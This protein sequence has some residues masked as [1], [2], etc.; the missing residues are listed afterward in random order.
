MGHTL[1]PCPM[2]HAAVAT[3]HAASSPTGRCT[4]AP[5]DPRSGVAALEAAGGDADGAAE[6]LMHDAAHAAQAVQP[7]SGVIRTSAHIGDR[8]SRVGAP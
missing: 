4:G 2:Q 1:H 3:L 7:P 5:S 6:L 8:L